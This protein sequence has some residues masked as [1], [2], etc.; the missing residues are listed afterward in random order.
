MRAFYPAL[1]KKGSNGAGIADFGSTCTGVAFTSGVALDIVFPVAEEWL[2]GLRQ[3][4]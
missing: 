4:S 2:S 1:R 3:R